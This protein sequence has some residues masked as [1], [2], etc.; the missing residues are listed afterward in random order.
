MRTRFKT[1]PSV[2]EMNSHNSR[3]R[4]NKKVWTEMQSMFPAGSIKRDRA[5]SNPSKSCLSLLWASETSAEELNIS[6]VLSFHNDTI[7]PSTIHLNPVPFKSVY[8][9][10]PER[11]RPNRLLLIR[12]GLLFSDYYEQHES[13]QGLLKH[14][15]MLLDA[16]LSTSPL[17]IPKQKLPTSPHPSETTNDS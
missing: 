2:Q 9:V 13:V 1:R 4:V 11:L 15:L 5:Q 6:T 12:P 14:P 7:N 16:T 10:L 8:Q 3:E 17:A